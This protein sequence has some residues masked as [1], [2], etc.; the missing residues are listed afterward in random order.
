M[1]SQGMNY[2]FQFALIH[3]SKIYA[4]FYNLCVCFFFFCTKDT[5]VV[6]VQTRFHIN[7]MEL[8]V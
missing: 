6:N 3:C 5:V 8:K 2:E 4:K 7:G 1:E